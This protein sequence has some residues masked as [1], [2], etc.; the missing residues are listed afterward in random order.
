M[1]INILYHNFHSFV[2]PRDFAFFLGGKSSSCL[3]TFDNIAETEQ[4]KQFRNC[5]LISVKSSK[6]NQRTYTDSEITE[7][8][9]HSVE[10]RDYRLHY[11]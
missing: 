4:R 1:V 11:E 2:Y 9:L 7:T 3:A 5:C 10:R 6:T 8:L